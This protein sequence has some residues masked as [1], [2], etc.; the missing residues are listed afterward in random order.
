L[1]AKKLNEL[2]IPV[3][4]CVGNHDLFHRHTREIHSTVPFHEFK[5]F[6]IINDPTVVKEIADGALISPYLF[7]EEYAGLQELR[8]LPFWAGHFEFK[9]FVI[10]GYNVVMPTGPDPSEYSGPSHILSGHFHKRQSSG[11]IHYIGN[12]FP[13][14][15]GDAGDFKRG[16]A[17]MDHVAGKLS[18]K[19]WPNC[20]KYIK[21]AL[22]DLL[23][24]EVSITTNTRVKCIVDVPLSFEE[25]TYIKQKYSGE[26]KIREFTMEDAKETDASITD[27]EVSGD[28]NE[29]DNVDEL[30]LKM[31]QDIKNDR[32]ENSKLIEIYGRLKL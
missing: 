11:N 21:V 5:N 22:T 10:T 27:T 13:M 9:G 17:V 12:T 31:L 18:F 6:T 30:V 29:L 20:P 23:E 1:G 32:I 24:G 14:D 8:T 7:P 15:F 3:Y 16:M 4:F 19:D 26:L 28:V 2:G 25:S